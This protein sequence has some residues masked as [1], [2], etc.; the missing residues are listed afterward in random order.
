MSPLPFSVFIISKDEERCIGRVIDSVIDLADEVIVI[1]SGSIDNTCQI[2]ESKGARVIFNEWPGYGAQK[3]FGEEQCRNDWILNLDS[4]EVLS[5]ALRDEIKGLFSSGLPDDDGYAIKV[6]TVYAFHP[7]PR[8]LSEY[9]SVV[10]LY[11]KRQ[12]RFPDHPTWD[13]ITPAKGKNVRELSAVCLHFSSPDLTHYVDKFNRY[14]S[15]QAREQKLKPR[16][17]LVMR[18]LLGFPFDFLKSYLFKR[19]FTGG[20]YGFILAVSHAY[21][22][23][24]KNAKMLEQHLEKD[25]SRESE[26]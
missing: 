21:S 19:H 7:E 24:L 17:V 23:F 16:T 18:L 1:D 22:R 3:R 6:T 14:T 12:M 11:N 9:N 2:A 5:P 8:F 25:Q 10:R 20:V 26:Q 15:L 4:D 13:A